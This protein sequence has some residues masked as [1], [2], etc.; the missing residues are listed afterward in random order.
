MSEI[1]KLNQN[2]TYYIFSIKPIETSYGT[3]YILEDDEFNKYWSNN[4]VNKFIKTNKIKNN[5]GSKLLFKIKTGSEKE[6]KKGEDVIRF[7]ETRC[8]SN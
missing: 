1:S 5:D 8:I 7:I 2:E 6:F 4:T 3:S